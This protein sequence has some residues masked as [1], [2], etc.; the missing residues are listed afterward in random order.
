MGTPALLAA[1]SGKILSAVNQSAKALYRHAQIFGLADDGATGPAAAAWVVTLAVDV[2]AGLIQCPSG[3]A[4]EV[5]AVADD[6]SLATWD[7]S[8]VSA[9]Q[10][11][12]AAIVYDCSSGSAVLTA[13]WGEA[14]AH[15][16]AAAP[17]DSDIASSLGSSEFVRVA[18]VLAYNSA[19]A[20]VSTVWN[21]TAR[22]GFGN[23]DAG[24]DGDLATSE[25]A[26][27][28]SLS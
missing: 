20:V 6:T 28:S 7:N 12:V 2:P 14:A 1:Q 8:A 19:A 10:D 17:S 3:T 5:A 22:S 18:D 26:W 13:V 24:F 16:D 21:N 11:A 27:N 9:A 4:Y 15:D 23:V 25:T